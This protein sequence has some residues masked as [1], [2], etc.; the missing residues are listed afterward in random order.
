MLNNNKF[1]INVI[2]IILFV[3]FLGGGGGGV[4]LVFFFVVGGGGGGGGGSSYLR[5][6][7]SYGESLL[8]VNGCKY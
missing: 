8:P 6:F 2:S 3:R 5:I 4:V 1:K 7:H